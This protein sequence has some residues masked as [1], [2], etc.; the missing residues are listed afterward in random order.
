M[1]E[2]Y[3]SWDLF[4]LPLLFVMGKIPHSQ[5]LCV[6]V[7]K[8]SFSLKPSSFMSLKYLTVSRE[9]I[10]KIKRLYLALFLPNVPEDMS[11]IPRFDLHF[12][13]QSFALLQ[14]PHAL[15][16][17][18]GNFSLSLRHRWVLPPPFSS[19]HVSHRF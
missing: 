11:L 19:Q 14:A 10:I 15:F 7:K 16:C 4:L 3:Q 9:G 18:P 13:V 1:A 2:I 12:S 8:H 17:F 5:E 6:A